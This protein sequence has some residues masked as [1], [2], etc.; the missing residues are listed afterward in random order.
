MKSL[1]HLVG[2]RLGLGIIA[3]RNEAETADSHLDTTG[4]ELAH[5]SEV[6]LDERER[7]RHRLAVSGLSRQFRNAHFCDWGRAAAGCAGEVER[8]LENFGFVRL[9]QIS[10]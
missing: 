8:F 3:C 6:C 2:N 10:T 7:I 4:I 5:R 1:G 9:D